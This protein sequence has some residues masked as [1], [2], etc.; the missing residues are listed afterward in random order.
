MGGAAVGN[1]LF[2]HLPMGYLGAAG[3][4]TVATKPAAAAGAAKG[5]TRAVTL[6]KKAKG[7]RGWGHGC[8][9]ACG[10]CRSGEG[11]DSCRDVEEEGQGVPRVG[12]RLRRSLRRLPER[13]RERLVP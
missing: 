8:D 1:P 13:R 6:K 11:K 9:E 2:D 12:T 3:G 4:D 7:C 10:G 5:K